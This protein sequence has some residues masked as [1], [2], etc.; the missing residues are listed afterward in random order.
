VL[1]DRATGTPISD[2]D[3]GFGPGPGASPAM[4]ARFAA[5]AE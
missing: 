1:V 2:L 4:R 5:L 3:A